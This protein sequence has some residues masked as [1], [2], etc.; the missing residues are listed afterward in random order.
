MTERIED[1]QP[2]ALWGYFAGLAKIPRASKNESAAMDWIE[3]VARERRA[4]TRR[5]AV[6]NLLV[7]IA[8]SPGREGAPAVLLQSHVDMVCEKNRDVVHDFERD[9]IRPVIDGEWVRAQGTT[10]GA[11]NGIGVAA[12]LA[13]LDEKDAVHGPLELLFTIDEET[14]LTG[15]SAVEP[16][17][18]SAHYMVNLDSEEI[19]VFTVG[20]AGGRDTTIALKARRAPLAGRE[21]RRVAVTG[22]QGG[23]SG[24]DI[25]KNR[26]NSI[27]ILAR[28]LL[29]AAEDPAVGAISIG[30]L[31][32][33]SKRNAIPREAWATVAADPGRSEALRAALEREATQVQA[34]LK[35][36]D[37]RVQLT[38]EPAPEMGCGS[39]G[40][41]EAT[42]VSDPEDSLRLLRLLNALPHGVL[43]MSVDIPGLVETSSNVGVVNDL[44]DGW[45]ISCS[46]R[47]S[48]GPALEGVLAQ[49]RSVARLAGAYTIHNDGYPGWK[50]NLQSPLLARAKDVHRKL[51]Q[52]DAE[53][54]AIHAG[55]ECGLLTEKYPEL[56][57]LSYGPDIQG[58]HSPDE[59]VRIP[60][61]AKMWAFT[62]AL[63]EDLAR[64]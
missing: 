63:L 28:L 19:G 61:V 6:G 30:A 5:D 2:R 38:I 21:T 45:Q 22:L 11:D 50:P 42:H 12:A 3:K 37:D 51:F 18:F 43:A 57:I 56:D 54:R 40:Q 16:G 62:V 33:G 48:V 36:I 46:S 15:A 24:T 27:K 1:L 23:H 7:R 55:L 59:R 10:L 47:S 44:T 32:G 39:Q 52:K 8:A 26:G 13:F 41:A 64:S 58:A 35:G 17:F 53:V 25:H 20:C 29:A 4:E 60:T 14:G 49:V 34:Q 31:A 9:P